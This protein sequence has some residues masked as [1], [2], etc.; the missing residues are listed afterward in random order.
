M[1]WLH[2]QGLGKSIIGKL[3]RKTLWKKYVYRA[4]QMGKRCEGIYISC[5]CSLKSDFIRGIQ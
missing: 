3:V 4:L 5:K 2:V 1:N